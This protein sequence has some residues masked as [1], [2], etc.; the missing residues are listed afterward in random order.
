MFEVVISG[1][2]L[3]LFITYRAYKKAKPENRTLN[4]VIECFL[5]SSLFSSV[6]AGVIGVAST[7]LIFFLTPFI[8]LKILLVTYTI[9]FLIIC[10]YYD[11]I[12]EACKM[13]SK[14]RVKL[15]D[16]VQF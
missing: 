13:M 15:L 9:I 6:I 10:C 2:W 7:L 11:F 16:G 5:V 14:M 8:S 1:I 4:N 3:G 12:S